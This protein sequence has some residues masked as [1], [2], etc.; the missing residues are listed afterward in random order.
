MIRLHKEGITFS[1]NND[2]ITWFWWWTRFRTYYS[3]IYDF[4]FNTIKDYWIHVGSVEKP[5]PMTKIRGFSLLDPLKAWIKYHFRVGYYVILFDIN[6]EAKP[7]S[8]WR[9]IPDRDKKLF[10]SE[11]VVLTC[12]DAKEMTTLCDSVDKNFAA[13]MGI[14][15]GEVVYN[16]EF[17]HL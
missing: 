10:N 7:A 15:N 9:S 2:E 17:S 11:L 5:V 3:L 12:K 13:A 14:V 4:H 16:N 6:V 1:Y 8:F